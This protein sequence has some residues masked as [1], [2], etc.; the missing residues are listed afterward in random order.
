MSGELQKPRMLRR[1]SCAMAVPIFPG[2]VPM[3][4]AGLRANEFLP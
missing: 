3:I 1:W 2:D 4:A